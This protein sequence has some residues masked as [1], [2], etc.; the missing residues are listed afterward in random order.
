[1]GRGIRSERGKRELIHRGYPEGPL[2]VELEFLLGGNEFRVVREYSP[3]GGAAVLEKKED[4]TWRGLASGEQLVNQKIEET[5]GFDYLTF[6]SSVFLPQGETLSFVEATPAERFKTL[7]S[8][9][10]LELL[11]LIRERVKEELRSLERELLPRED[12]L[13]EREEE[14]LEERLNLVE[15]EKEDLEKRATV[16]TQEEEKKEEK[17]RL[18]GN[19]KDIEKNEKELQKRREDLEKE[20]NIASQKAREDREIQKA[21]EVKVSFWQPWRI[22]VERIKSWEEEK[23]T[24]LEKKTKIEEE[25]TRLNKELKKIRLQ[26]EEQNT[27]R[28]NLE[29]YEDKLRQ[30]ASPL[31]EEARAIKRR[32]QELEKD[33]EERK[34]KIKEIEKAL[35]KE[36]KEKEELEKKFVE[37]KEKTEREEEI[38]QKVE[39][40]KEKIEPLIRDLKEKEK[41]I[42]LISEELKSLEEEIKTC[43]KGYEDLDNEWSKKRKEL[44]LWQEEREI[45]EESYRQMVRDF[46]LWE[47]EK[48]WEEKGIC[49]LCGSDVP[50]PSEIEAFPE[51]DWEGYHSFQEKGEKLLEEESSL[52]QKK[53][54]EEKKLTELKNKEREKR[55][56]QE[57]L[58]EE[59]GKILEALDSIDLPPL[60]EPEKIEEFLKKKREEREKTLVNLY[61]LEKEK[62]VKKAK[63]ENR[64][65]EKDEEQEKIRNIERNIKEEEKLLAEKREQL[66]QIFTLLRWED[67]QPPEEVFNDLWG[68]FLK[69]LQVLSQELEKLG[70][71]ESRI[72]EKLKFLFQ[73]KKEAE[74]KIAQ[75]LQGGEELQKE[76]REKKEA[77]QKELQRL[78]WT[79]EY[80]EQLRDKKA[81]NWQ[82]RWHRLEGELKQVEKSLQLY[83]ESKRNLIHQLGIE[84]DEVE[85]LWEKEIEELEKIRGELG[86]SKERKGSLDKE[87]ENLRDRIEERD[88]LR[89]E[90]QE[91]RKIWELHY[92]L[93]KAL[94]ARGFRSYLLGFLF[95]ELEEEAS[96]FLEDLSQGR[97]FLRMKMEEG[98]AEMVVVD[99]N[100]GG[101]ERLPSECSGGEKTLIALSLA[102]ALSRIHLREVGKERGADCLFIDEGFSA[103][104][105]EHL[106]L[107]ADAI[108]RLSQDGRMVGIVTHDPSFASYFPLHLE[109]K[110]GKAFWKRNEEVI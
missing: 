108:L 38:L 45:K 18:L 97:Y 56:E 62:E 24:W 72:E 6:K 67:S 81:G 70:K 13:K 95:R 103:L 49:P 23:R 88:K 59:K 36:R 26:L 28:K 94:E 12:R 101:E 8:L 50:P 83:E 37:E 51:I 90:L 47:L 34:E 86:E 99:K 4:N 54:Q 5:L 73:S 53:I 10:G 42:S 85:E 16:L 69:R 82:E 58:K 39:K 60:I 110:G 91:K 20:I 15:K 35:Q 41:E 40:T 104:D 61:Q 84:K 11:D 22:V 52:R 43:S 31:A 74:E 9:F 79:E 76:E 29:S 27:R 65:K 19:L 1:F 17:T 30:E 7:S 106:E 107:V 75:L 55:E 25:I 71:E 78:E 48:E 57:K 68:K 63:I 46:A 100:Y 14:N 109:V 92:Q 66:S 44:L 87:I 93:D 105:Q 102:L 64:I 32:L 80:F 3:R 21:W 2:R 96:S 89:E 77:F 98:K 33:R